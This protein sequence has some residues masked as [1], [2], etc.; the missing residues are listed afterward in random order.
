M[1]SNP[2][3]RMK[4][5]NLYGLPEPLVRAV[6]WSDRNREGC[7]YTITELDRPPRIAALERQF[8][9]EIEEDAS[10]RLWMLLGSAGHEVL[11]R[12]ASKSRIVEERAIAEVEVDGKMFKIGGQIDYS[13][14]EKAIWDYKFVSLWATKEG[15]RQEWVEQLNC[16]RWLAIQYGVMIERLIIVA[17]F[18]DWSKSKAGREKS[19]PQSQVQVFDLP[20]WTDGQTLAWLRH[21]I[22]LHEAA[23]T[24]LPE[25]TADDTWEKP[26]QY[27][28]KKKGNIRA[29]NVYDKREDAEEHARED[30]LEL[31]VRPATRPRCED[32]CHCAP[33]CEQFKQFKGLGKP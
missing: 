12:S 33:F 19:Y 15:P 29:T 32:Y 2:P 14:V 8:G 17:I 3:L 4:L 7:D 25:C 20:I 18:R 22:R 24:A 9:D 1:G 10:D 21:R 13:E 26:A 28:V 23:K 11:R 16:Y 5:T 27:A 31:E 6:M 30:G